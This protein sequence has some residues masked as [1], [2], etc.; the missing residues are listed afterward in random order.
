MVRKSEVIGS[1]PVRV[2]YLVIGV[3]Q[4]PAMCGVIYGTMYHKAALKSFDKSRAYPR[5]GA[6][7][8]HHI[9]IIVQK[10]TTNNNIHS[11]ASVYERYIDRN[12]HVSSL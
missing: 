12:V 9:A 1:N 8:C 4:R 11:L 3:V 2:G 10:E 6:S 5:L 7:F